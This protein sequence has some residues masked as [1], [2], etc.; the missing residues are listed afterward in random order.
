MLRRWTVAVALLLTW[1]TTVN[2]DVFRPA[3]L[4]LRQTGA[5]R[6]DVM[7]KVPAQGD[8]LRLAIHVLA[9]Q[10]ANFSS[11]GSGSDALLASVRLAVQRAVA[12][13]RVPQSASTY[14]QDRSD[15]RLR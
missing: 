10:R 14:A 2:A 8:A 9:N 12:S 13:P 7:W 1:V 15:G 6:Y 3:Y 5:E 11:R 4:E